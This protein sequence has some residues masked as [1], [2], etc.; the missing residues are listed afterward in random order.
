MNLTAIKDLVQMAGRSTTDQDKATSL[1][2]G[3]VY[4]ARL[5]ENGPEAAEH[6]YVRQD[7]ARLVAEA[8]EALRRAPNYFGAAGERERERVISAAQ[9]G[10]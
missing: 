8:A 6:T 5:V 4:L 2:G 9:A 3:V 10:L 7:A 1:F